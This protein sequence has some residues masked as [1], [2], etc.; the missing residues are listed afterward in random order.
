MACLVVHVTVSTC[1]FALR[2]SAT[3]GLISDIKTIYVYLLSGYCGHG[4]KLKYVLHFVSLLHP[5]Q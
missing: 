1:R 5:V 4:V 2:A 3:G